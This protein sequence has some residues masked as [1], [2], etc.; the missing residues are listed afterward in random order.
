MD[1]GHNETEELLTEL[2]KKINKTYKRAYVETQAKLDKYLSDFV[3][4]EK[5]KKMLVIKGEMTVK[6]YNEWRLGQV[7]IGQ[8]WREMVNTLAYDYVNADKIARALTSEYTPEVY[9]L[10]H[11]Y[12]TFQVEKES[13]VDTSYTLYDKATVER[14]IKDNP[15]LLP[16]LD[17]LSKTAE[18]IRA[19]KI[20]RW[21]V[22]KITAEVTQGILQGE[23]VQKISR[24]LRNVTDMDYR[25]SIRN[26]RTAFTGAQNAGRVDAYKRA[27]GMGIDLMQ[28]W[29]AILDN[30]TRHAHRELDGQKVKAGEPFNVDGYEIKYPGDRT[31]PGYLVYNCRCTLKPVLKG[32]EHDFRKDL[33][34]DDGLKRISYDEWVEGEHRPKKKR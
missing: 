21:N 19:G 34:F 20:Q 15:D 10:N 8:R 4:K 6:E 11:N 14:L 7:M 18:D 29:V 22:Q 5:E 25:A 13:L 26:A 9:A 16:E 1:I 12:A 17:P 30:R 3:R 2:E 31:A 27:E 23:S 33:V 32:F 24:R 28:E